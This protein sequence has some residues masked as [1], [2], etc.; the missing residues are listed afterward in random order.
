M[1]SA[2]KLC[3]QQPSLQF[4]DRATIPLEVELVSLLPLALAL[5]LVMVMVMVMA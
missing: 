3:F 5:E 1:S 2:Y 4:L